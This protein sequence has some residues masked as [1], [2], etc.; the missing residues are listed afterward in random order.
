MNKK[1]K[2]AYWIIGSVILL[3]ALVYFSNGGFLA[4]TGSNSLSLTQASL[5]SSNPYLSGKVWLLTFSAGGLGQS[6]YG[7]I[8]PSQ[9]DAFTS[10]SSTTTKNLQI[11]VDY[12]D[13]ECLYPIQSGG[14][15]KPIYDIELKE[16]YCTGLFLDDATVKSSTGLQNLL[17][18]GKYGASFTCFGIGYNTLSQVGNFGQ[19][20]IK[21]SYT[22]NLNVNG[23]TAS[24]TINTLDGST[25]GSIGNYAYASWAGNLVSGQSCPQT[26]DTLYRPAYINGQ[27]R[28]INKQNYEAYVSTINQNIAGLIDQGDKTGITNWVNDLKNKILVSK[29]SQSFG[30]IDNS[31][32]LTNAQVKVI[33]STPLQFPVTTLYIKA[34]TLGIYTPVP[35]FQIVSKSSECFK[36]GNTGTIS[37]VIKNNGETGTYNAYASCSGVFTAINNAQG[38]LSSGASKTINL[39]LTAT[40]SSKQTSSCTLTIES[41]GTTKTASVNVCV[42]PQ[43]TC[44]VPYPKK[45]CGFSGSTEVI[46]QCSSDGAT[47]NIIQNCAGN[48]YCDAIDATCKLE[49]SGNQGGTTSDGCKWYDVICHVKVAFTK[50]VDFLTY[51]KYALIIIFSLITYFILVDNLNKIPSVRTK[52]YIAWILS[53]IITGLSAYALILFIGSVFFWVSLIAGGVIFYFLSPILIP[54]LARRLL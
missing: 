6:Y 47:T 1:Q 32:S 44:T 15:L 18:K 14:L 22:I 38:S 23:Q 51:L 3:L 33:S 9:V 35:D 17:Y 2:T 36:T 46:Q 29:S 52:S 28:L 4:V 53:F 43:I 25:Q 24:K 16:Y 39:P 8:T 34:D 49:T 5:Q 19:T 50:T 21:S 40:A 41:T 27:W 42:D 11:N 20:N 45:F 37:A 48:E 31:A 30:T 26:T 12:A 7:T 10:D 54:L 13:T